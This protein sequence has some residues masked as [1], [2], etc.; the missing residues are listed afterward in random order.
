MNDAYF[1]AEDVLRLAVQTAGGAVGGE[2]PSGTSREPQVPAGWVDSGAEADVMCGLDFDSTEHYPLGFYDTWVDRDIAGEPFK[3]S[4]PFVQ[5]PDDVALLRSGMPFPVYCCWN[6]LLVAN[7]EPFYEGVRF[8]R[9]TTGECAASEC[10]LFCKDFWHAN[11]RKFA[12][13]PHVRV[14]YERDT[15]EKLHAAPWM[16]TGA[17]ELARR[18]EW[19]VHVPWPPYPPMRVYCC[20]L[21]GSG[22]DA[23][24]GCRHEETKLPD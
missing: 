9:S 16:D 13:D 14:A 15:Y 12:I 10:S 5:R 4:A 18:V 11:K 22:R 23:D 19:P 21:E 2:R 3:K 6:G 7:A 24:A 1:C 20:G 17:A 8:R